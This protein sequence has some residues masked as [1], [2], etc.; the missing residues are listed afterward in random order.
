M[1]VGSSPVHIPTGLEPS[2]VQ[3]LVP[4][5]LKENLRSQMY[6]AL[7]P[8]SNGEMALFVKK[9]CPFANI[10]GSEHM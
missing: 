10:G 5:P 4:V 1:Q 3:V 9:I 7:V 8:K 6:V 2:P